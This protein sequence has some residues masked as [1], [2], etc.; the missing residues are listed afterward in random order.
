[1]RRIQSWVFR[2]SI[3]LIIAFIRKIH[4]WPYFF[5]R[6][7][8]GV[9]HD[10][11]LYVWLTEE[12]YK[13]VFEFDFNTVAFYP[14]GHS[15]AWSDNYIL[16]SL[17]I[18]AIDWIVL[19]S[20]DNT[21]LLYNLCSLIVD[22]LNGYCTYRLVY[23][24]ARNGFVA[25]YAGIAFQTFGFFSQH[26]GH[27]Q[28][29]WAFWLPLTIEFYYR[30]LLNSNFT[31][32]VI[33]IV[34]LILSFTTSVYYSIFTVLALSIITLCYVIINFDGF[35][36]DV[37]RCLFRNI[38]LKHVIILI[39]CLPLILFLT[40]PYLIVQKSFGSRDLWESYYFAAN[41]LSYLAASA[42]SYFYSSFSDY[43]HAEAR[44]FPG[45]TVLLV[46]LI[47]LMYAFYKGSAV[48]FYG[49][50][51]RQGM[52]VFLSG[53]LFSILYGTSFESHYLQSLAIIAGWV[54]LGLLFYFLIKGREE[55]H[56]INVFMIIALVFLL[57]SLGPIFIDQ[58]AAILPTMNGI[59]YDYFPGFKGIRAVSRAGV[60]VIWCSCIIGGLV[61][62]KLSINRWVILVL[63]LIVLIENWH[64]IIPIE[65]LTAVPEVLE[66]VPPKS[67][68]V[69]L[70]FVG[71]L[72]DN[73]MVKSWGEFSKNNIEAMLWFG[74][75]ELKTVNGY[76]GQRTFIMHRLP[77]LVRNFPDQLSLK[78]LMR[79]VN[80]RYVLLRSSLLREFDIEEFNRKLRRL[81]VYTRLL[82]HDNAGNFLVRLRDIRWHS[83]THLLRVPGYCNGSL[84]LLVSSGSSLVGR[85]ESSRSDITLSY[86]IEGE[87]EH[88]WGS[89][90]VVGSKLFKIRL[91]K[92]P[93]GVQPTEL[94]LN[95]SGYFNTAFAKFSCE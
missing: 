54:L 22:A 17:L 45:F 91:K 4:V 94:I 20:S 63:S 26:S 47:S 74:A 5:N 34:L 51:A 68:I 77:F 32:I 50:A 27:P 37:F 55:L 88:T 23:L 85:N 24:L 46:T 21:P 33:V 13:A 16:P 70:P 57:I 43:S 80:L 95:S 64:P 62:A 76:S 1:M 73:G 15:L 10:A 87:G 92:G 3:F 40:R 6:Y 11:G 35:R 79:I 75:R 89:M 42:L 60:V 82:A 86:K 61:L 38:D 72:K 30:A 93:I 58:G 78:Y 36:F 53:I 83:K 28:L 69:S 19:P 2:L 71:E 67:V 65:G 90:P 25:F 7:I 14:F 29:Q 52:V 56:T 49:N 31:S 59:A 81:R 84:R 8:G 48:F 66:Q 12:A 44:L 41:G 9:S 18:K 39:V